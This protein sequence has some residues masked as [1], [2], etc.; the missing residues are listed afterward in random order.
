MYNYK[1]ETF[2]TFMLELH[3]YVTI[4]LTLVYKEIIIEQS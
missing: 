2:L 1:Q 4:S 3:V